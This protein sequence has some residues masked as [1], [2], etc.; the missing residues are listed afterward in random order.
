MCPLEEMFALNSLWVTKYS[1]RNG[2]M[3]PLS[4]SRNTKYPL[5]SCRT[6]FLAMTS[7]TITP[8]DHFPSVLPSKEP[9]LLCLLFFYLE[10]FHQNHHG[11]FGVWKSGF[12]LPTSGFGNGGPKLRSTKSSWPVI[13]LIVQQIAFRYHVLD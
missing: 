11:R 1:H 3:V 13:K 5:R 12:H 4:S 7:S 10:L 6:L 9:Q 2:G 8:V